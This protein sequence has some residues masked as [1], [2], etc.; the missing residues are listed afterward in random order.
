MIRTQPPDHRDTGTPQRQSPGLLRVSCNWLR[1]TTLL[2]VE[3]KKADIC[4]LGQTLAAHE[5]CTALR[6]YR[7]RRHLQAGVGHYSVFSGRRWQQ[8]IHP[9]V[10]NTLLAS[11]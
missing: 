4:S 8:Q 3:G 6:Q 11:E 10:R 9:I 2:T 1:R 5:L 7:R